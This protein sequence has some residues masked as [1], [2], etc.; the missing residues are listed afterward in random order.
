MKRNVLFIGFLPL[1]ALFVWSTN[2]IS[3]VSRPMP[4]SARVSS[5]PTETPG[6]PWLC[7][8]CAPAGA[9]HEKISVDVFQTQAPAV[10]QSKAQTPAALNTNGLQASGVLMDGGGDSVGAAAAVMATAAAPRAAFRLPQPTATLWTALPATLTAWPTTAADPAPSQYPFIS[11]VTPHAHQIF[12]LGQNLGNRANVFSKIGDSI[13]A[14]EVFLAPIGW[15]RYDLHQYTYLAPVIAYFSQTNARTANSFANTSLA[16]KGGWTAG[17]VINPD[18]VFNPD[19]CRP[20]ENP[21]ECE[22][23]VVKPSVGLIMIGTNDV[24][25]TSATQYAA[26]LRQILQTSLNRGIIPV[27]STIPPMHHDWAVGR[28]EAIN[29]I[30][31][32][33]AREYD[34]PLWD[35]WSALQSLSNDPLSS[36]GIHPSG[37]TNRAADF[38]QDGL[39]TGYTVR[40]LLALQALDAVWQAALH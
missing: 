1:M 38:S 16:A 33:L 5:P 31:V 34:V 18:A 28:V 8:G 29:A 9:A 37:Y 3:A 20:N 24:R 39:R 14:N 23:R 26:E 21:L 15:G 11:G 22:F 19:L 6:Q 10:P 40:N 30:I 17:Q 4:T 7:E 27:I 36:D 32:S 25:Y 13:T 35:Y 12:L 2:K